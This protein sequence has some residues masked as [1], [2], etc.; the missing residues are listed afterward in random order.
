MS[1]NLLYGPLP[2]SFAGLRRLKWLGLS[3][4]YFLNGSIPSDVMV[5]MPSLTHLE[6]HYNNFTGNI[7]M[8]NA[9]S[10]VVL[11]RL[12]VNS[13]TGSI[14]HS[15]TEIKALQQLH[16]NK[17]YLDGSIPKGI[18]QL[19]RL[20][21]LD[22]SD[23]YLRNEVPPLDK[24]TNLGYLDLHGNL[25]R[26]KM[27]T[28]GAC[29]NLVYLDL[30]T[31][32]FQGEISSRLGN[33]SQLK[34]VN[35]AQNNFTGEVL[36]DLSNLTSLVFFV[37]S[38]NTLSGTIPA[39]SLNSTYLRVMDYSRNH[40]TGEIPQETCSWSGIM[41]LSFAY[42]KLFGQIPDCTTNLIWL[43]ILDLSNNKLTG[44][45]PRA[46][47]KFQGFKGNTSGDL[48][49]GIYTGVELS[50]VIIVNDARIQFD[51]TTIV[52]ANNM[53]SL[54]ISS[55]S[56]EGVIPEEIGQLVGLMHLNL[57][58]NQFTGAIPLNLSSLK[59]LQSLDLSWNMLQG[60]IPNEFGELPLSAFNV[61]FNNLSGLVPTAYNLNTRFPLA[62]QGNKNL[63]GFPLSPCG[64]A[65]KDQEHPASHKS[66]EKDFLFREAS[67][68]AFGCGVFIGFWV[69]FLGITFWDSLQSWRYKLRAKE[70]EDASIGLSIPSFLPRL[71]S[72]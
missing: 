27:P 70:H 45:L 2:G 5:G 34:V 42:N 59:K 30:S 24:C 16:L 51:R 32:E 43:Q 67:V 68:W 22:L 19:D 36:L 65:T 47:W 21:I 44:Q 17:N 20:E 14:P 3:R 69:T 1:D 46:L 28:F 39:K 29:T 12:D 11:L 64:Y 52:V 18:S 63:C 50:L 35:F 53:T 58:H 9:S 10:P 4:N 23:N 62:F 37:I 40:F 8:F 72:S 48:N 57:S 61:S 33:C 6:L 26:S 56:L 41:I 71:G 31:N 66:W 15:I 7:P 55:N 38:N 54:D 49:L 25:I 60:R 13:L